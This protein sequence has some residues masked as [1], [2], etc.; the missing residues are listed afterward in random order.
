MVSVA[1]I[2]FRATTFEEAWT[3]CRG[4]LTG[5]GSVFEPGV[6]RAQLQFAP[7]SWFVAGVFGIVLME[8]VEAWKAQEKVKAPTAVHPW[9]LRWSLYY[10]LVVMLLFL[11]TPEAAQFIYFQF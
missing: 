5:W 7:M 9:W 4:L 11:S 3:I 6:L 10:A 1:W 8:A 2:F